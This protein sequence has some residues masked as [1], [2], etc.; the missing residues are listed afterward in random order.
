M[1]DEPQD[2]KR[3]ER[4]LDR[5]EVEAA[6]WRIAILSK[7]G[8]T[9]G[10]VAALGLI[11]FLLFP[12]RSNDIPVAIPSDQEVGA[13]VD[14]GQESATEDE[15]SEEPPSNGAPV[16]VLGEDPKGD[17]ENGESKPVKPEEDVPGADIKSVSYESGPSE[18]PCFVIDVYGD[19]DAAALRASNYIISVDVVGPDGEVW[20][21]RAEFFQ[22]EPDPGLV[23]LGPDRVRLEGAFMTPFWQS[24]D[25]L[26][27]CVDSGETSL[28]VATFS[29]TIFVLTSGGEYSD[30][31]EGV[32]GS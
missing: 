12:A 18:E 31:A 20:Q 14:P 22:G 26:R 4:P 29:V 10:G 1:P 19:G 13:V 7:R 28:A 5:Q 9:L 6:K 25:I 30:S 17:G 21:A 27:V 15:P 23:R 2:A 8:K 3:A 24:P 32:A 11:A 16:G